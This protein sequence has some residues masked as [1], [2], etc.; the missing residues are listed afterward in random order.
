MKLRIYALLLLLI[1]QISAAQK[2]KEEGIF[3]DKTFSGIKFRSIGPSFMSGRIADIAFHPQDPNVWYVGVGSGGV[4]KTVNA[5][6]TWTP[7]FDNESVYSI[8]SILIDHNNPEIIWVGTG[9]NV[10]GRHVSFGDGIYRSLDG[11]KSWQNMG[12]KKSQHISTMIMHP[13]DS[14]TLWVAVQGPLWSKGGERGLYKT[15][16]AGK[17][18]KNTL[19]DDAWV[20]VTDVVIDPR[21]PDVLYAA[22]WQ[23]HRN[24][25]AYMG[26]GPGTGLHRSLDGGETWTELKD[27]LP[28][29]DMGKI[30]LAIS[31]MKPDVL[32]AAIEL[33]R[34]KGAVYKSENRGMSW[35]KQSDTVSGG[36]GPHYYQELYASPHQFDRLYLMDVR[37]QVS[38]DGG[39]KFRRM[40][41]EFKH[42]DN[43]ALV[44]RADDPDYL[45]AG[46]DGGIYESFDLG[47]TWRYI[48][49]LP[50]TQYYKVAVDDAEPFYHV[51]GGTQ[52]NNT[53]GGPSRTDNLHG[54]R[55]AD[56]EVTLFGD[57]HQPA[58][59]PGNPDIM[60]SQWQQGNLMRV[61]RTTGE[62]VYIKPQPGAGENHE[63]FNW[64]APILVSPHKPSR[65]YFASHRVWRSED[66]GDS[67]TA[68][69]G[70]L[71]RDQDRITLPIMGGTQSWDASWDMYA[72][73]TY[74]TITSLAESPQQEGVIYAGTDDGLIQVTANGGENWKK[75]EAGSLP[76]V[77]KSAFVNDIKADLFDVNTAYVALDNHKFGDLQPYL[78]K[79]TN[80]GK[81][82]KSITSNLP[83]NHL[84]WRIVQDH[85]N[86]DL[87]FVGTEFGVFFTVNGGGKW[88]KITGGVPTISFRDLAIQRR[89]NDLIGATFGRGFYILDNYAMLRDVNASMLDQEAALFQ[90]RNAWW[91]IQRGLLGFSKKGAQGASMYA[92]DNPPFG[93]VFDYY[94][95]DDIATI[96]SARQAAEKK[97]KKDKKA[98][99]FP[100]WDALED[101][102]RQAKPKI[103][104]TVKDNDGQVVR[105]LH[106]PAKKGFHRVAWDLRF[107]DT[108]A[109]H[110]GN[111]NSD[112]DAEGHLALP[113]TYTVT[114]SKQ[115]DGQIVAL[116]E[117]MSFEVKRMRSPALKGAEMVEVEAFWK[118]LSEFQRSMTASNQVL[119]KSR[120]S[121]KLMQA[122]LARSTTAP[123]RLHNKLHDLQQDMHDFEQQLSGHKS[124]QAVGEKTKPTISERFNVAYFG[125]SGSSYGPTP[126]HKQSLEIAKTEY[127]ELKQKL[128]VLSEQRIPQL[129]QELLDAGAP[130]TTG[131]PLPSSN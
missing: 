60:Y 80:Q 82:W 79:T 58:T 99:Q 14:N 70:D 13:K 74:N 113:G 78:L 76:G 50:I 100:G 102:R 126:T 36:T 39:K 53:Q 98:L 109:I 21:D 20:G 91:Y 97:A 1:T 56:W 28:T 90:P 18:W 116:S 7:V 30:G 77:P 26:S 6:T 118:E 46:T 128:R 19:G 12:L 95:K 32:Y 54:I 51:Y 72:M 87:L 101:E 10:G 104:L 17:T 111:V 71:T 9:E 69:S 105:I 31:P 66:R 107:P 48:D 64:D 86:P 122:A 115:Q 96:K 62:L 73:S 52:D 38:D 24:V 41:E 130:W 124:K 44:F 22:T 40:K 4:W 63:R 125:T 114:L 15:T 59:E 42:S 121:L 88:T 8:G 49:N 2:N 119:N 68:I 131:S 37:I 45:M 112:D 16:D 81:T 92:A 84:V 65:L 35:T 61:D 85:V 103:V 34:R 89:E 75:I 129:Q 33:E 117:P 106:G 27:G 11:G 57:G 123:N 25:A 43:H 127:A 29:G 55:N 120:E 94:L 93:A 83:K 3:S 47:K 67:W 23:R 108:S 110:S 5:G